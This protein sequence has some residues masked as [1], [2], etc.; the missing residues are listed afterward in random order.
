MRSDLYLMALL[1]VSSLAVAQTNEKQPIIDMHLHA[2]EAPGSP[3]VFGCVPK[4]S[5]PAWDMKLSTHSS[6]KSTC[7]DPIISPNTSDE[8]MHETLALLDKFNIRAVA[9]GPPATVDRWKKAGGNRILPATTFGK[10]GG[11]PAELREWVKS[12]RI[13]AFAEIGTQYEGVPANSPLL[14]PYF[15]LAEELDIPVGIHMGPGPAGAPYGLPK[16]YRA[17]LS[18]LLLLENVLVSHPK[19]RIWAMHAGWPLADDAIATLYAYPQLYVDIGI[20]DY[21]LPQAEFYGYLKRLVDAGF[22]N[23]IMFGWDQMYGPKRY[24][25]QY[26]LSNQRH[27]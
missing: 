6:E 7:Q 23:R 14:E 16:D 2:L 4:D 9:S 3:V 24:R 20:I 11:S 15:A 12:G 19:L 21:L 5:F 22:E 27:F 26:T 25:L 17:Q 8:L 13:V 18:S 1:L 10:D